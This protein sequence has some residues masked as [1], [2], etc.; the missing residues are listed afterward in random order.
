LK[1]PQKAKAYIAKSLAKKQ[2][3]IV[4]NTAAKTGEKGKKTCKQNIL[5]SIQ[6]GKS[7]T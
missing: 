3:S 7:I 1:Q 5:K 4:L 6:Q 2:M